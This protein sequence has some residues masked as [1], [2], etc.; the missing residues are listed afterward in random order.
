MTVATIEALTLER[1][2][3]VPNNPRLP[4]LIYSS[5]FPP[6]MTTAATCE[7]IFQCNG[8][9]PQ[10][11]DSIYPFHHYHSTAHE[12][13]GFARGRAVLMLGGPGGPTVHVTA[14]DAVLLPVGTGH[15]RVDA[16]D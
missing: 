13:L 2:A 10:W 3:W 4:V 15:C 5:A 11:R 1:N 9:P 16:T 14:G 7:A 12:V 6:D 8:W